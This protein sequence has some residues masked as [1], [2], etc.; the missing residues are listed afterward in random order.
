MTATMR[1]LEIISKVGLRDTG[2]DLGS[3]LHEH[4]RPLASHVAFLFSLSSKLQLE[5]AS[6]RQE[7]RT[8][9]DYE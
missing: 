4:F 1:G 9:F 2:G 6:C 7:K 5:A 3:F 8:C